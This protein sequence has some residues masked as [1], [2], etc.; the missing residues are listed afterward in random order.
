MTLR[1]HLMAATMLIAL[2]RPAL[3]AEALEKKSLEIGTASLG[4]TYLPVIIADRKGFFRDEGLSVEIAAFAGGSK[5][6]EA[7]MGGSLDMVSGA[8]SN[9]L[10]MAAKGQKLVEFVEQ[11][12]CP[13]FQVLVSRHSAASLTAPAGLKGMNIGVSAPGSSTN[14]VLNYVLAKNGVDPTDVSIIGV[15]TSAAAVAAMRSGQIDAIIN[16]DPVLTILEDAGDARPIVDMRS[17]GPSEAVFG[18]PYPEASVYATA[19]FVRKN[20]H[21]VQAVTNAVVRAERWM[22]AATPDQIADAL[23]VEYLLGDRATYTR[24]LGSMR[25]C[26]SPDGLMTRTAADTVLRVLRSF[27]PD[28]RAAKIDIEATYDNSFVQNVPAAAR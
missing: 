14:M 18:G 23:P 1:R 6:L 10:T 16:S 17:P 25:G 3:A 8:Y 19:D 26:Y 12:R 11:I 2:C 5:A 22:A 15:G 21:T 13:G 4:L 28:V 9:T 20:P 24:A 7:L 27:D